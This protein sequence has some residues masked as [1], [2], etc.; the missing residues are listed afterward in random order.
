MVRQQR[1]EVCRQL[2]VQVQPAD[3]GD[4]RR[5]PGAPHP[6]SRE[7]G[8]LDLGGCLV[9]GIRQPAAQQ[10][11]PV[12]GQHDPHLF[13]ELTRR[14]LGRRFAGLG[15]AAGMHELVRAPFA[16]GQEAS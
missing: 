3:L 5:R 14:C 6:R 4:F 1:G 15:F 16:D 7:N 9:G 2:G 13:L 11:Q 12:R 8:G 10:V